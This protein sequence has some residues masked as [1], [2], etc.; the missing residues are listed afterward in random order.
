MQMGN[1]FSQCQPRETTRPKSKPAK[2]PRMIPFSTAR[3]APRPVRNHAKIP[4]C[5][6]FRVSR[7]AVR[8]EWALAPDRHPSCAAVRC[9][10]TPA[11]APKPPPNSSQQQ[12][13]HSRTRRQT[14]TRRWSRA[15]G[16]RIGWLTWDLPN[17]TRFC[18]RT[19]SGGYCECDALP[20]GQYATHGFC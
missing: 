10:M 15:S 20:N 2:P 17:Y 4:W 8:N 11:S 16:W 18:K 14:I 5:K 19:R 9:T 13:R 1:L 7:T 3:R 12:P 6:C